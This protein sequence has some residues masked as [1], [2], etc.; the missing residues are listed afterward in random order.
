MNA[1]T[2]VPATSTDE[3]IAWLSTRIDATNDLIDALQTRL[4]A[5]DAKLAAIEARVE[6]TNTQLA[7][8]EKL[9][10]QSLP[11]APWSQPA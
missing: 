6:S 3:A 7:A 1:S 11:G 10:I 4:E 8:L 5:H 9:T 2:P